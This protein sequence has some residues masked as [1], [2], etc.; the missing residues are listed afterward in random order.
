MLRVECAIAL[1]D[2]SSGQSFGLFKCP[3]R[4][5][6]SLPSVW[7]GVYSTYTRASFDGIA[8]A[9]KT[10]CALDLYNLCQKLATCNFIF[11]VSIA[12]GI[13]R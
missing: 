13:L 5:K 3:L 9:V 2:S 8:S 12:Q 1:R 10:R 4:L 6:S 7:F 11:R